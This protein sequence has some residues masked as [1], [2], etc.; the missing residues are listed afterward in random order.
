MSMQ[1]TALALQLSALATL[2][3]LLGVLLGRAELFVTVIPIAVAMFS[4][5]R[6]LAPEVQIDHLLSEDQVLEGGRIVV[7]VIVK[8]NITH[9][10]LEMEEP[11]PPLLELY[12]G[13]RR[14]VMVLSA[15]EERR[16]SYEL[17]CTASGR[18]ELGQIFVCLLNSGGVSE[19]QGWVRSVKFLRVYP[20]IVPLARLPRPSRTQSTLGNYPS[21]QM[22][23]GL[24]PGEIRA[25]APGD[26]IR[27]I[28]WKA[29]LRAGSLVVNQFQIEKN[30]DVVLLV[31]TTAESGA[32][33]YSS[34]DYCLRA[35]ATLGTS[36]LAH[37]D[38]V[39]LIELGGF[40]RWV[41]PGSGRLQCERILDALLSSNV[42]FS[43]LA[44]DLSF[45]P[46]R[47]LPAQALV[48][49]VTAL[50]DQHFPNVLE[51][52]VGRG[53]EVIVLVVSP[54]EVTRQAIPALPAGDLA[55]R[56]WRLDRRAR[57]QALRKAGL[58]VVEWDPC[59]PLSTA[60]AA[61]GQQPR[62]RVY[63]T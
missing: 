9:A 11:L 34:R 51:D 14:A 49:A 29:S 26:R 37:R 4:L 15:G 12:S 13:H 62:Y 5:K 39:G 42:T 41:R 46:S 18:F 61:L 30:A 3:L 23:E 2:G 60:V 56:I 36:Y 43:H 63:A 31:D 6:A 57:M 53:L 22:G 48:I 54:V 33:P 1:P 47:V 45:V 44:R 59:D 35:A 24:E 20:S 25:F 27:R 55:F 32:R 40:I 7:T 58:R 50:L 8:S 28:N 19:E 10:Y 21:R 38:R 52:L 16:W 17:R